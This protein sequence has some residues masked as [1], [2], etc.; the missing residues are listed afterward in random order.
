LT[1]LPGQLV[2]SFNVKLLDDGKTNDPAP[3]MFLW[4]SIP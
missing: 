2:K 1:F 4:R 3:A